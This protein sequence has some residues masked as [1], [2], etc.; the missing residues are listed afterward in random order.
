MIGKLREGIGRKMKK[1]EE[2]G[3]K[4]WEK[5][6]RK[7]NRKLTTAVLKHQILRHKLIGA[8]GTSTKLNVCKLSQEFAKLKRYLKGKWVVALNTQ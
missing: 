2:K 1:C 3:G 4:R 6:R 7:E 5:W 8:A